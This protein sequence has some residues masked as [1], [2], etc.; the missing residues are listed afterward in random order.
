MKRKMKMADDN[1]KEVELPLDYGDC[2]T[3]EERKLWCE[4]E[5]WETERQM[6]AEDDAGA[7]DDPPYGGPEFWPRS[8]FI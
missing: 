3:D 8:H 7:F 1:K 2:T 5:M 6:K 4:R